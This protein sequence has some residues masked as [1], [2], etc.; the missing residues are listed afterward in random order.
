MES[1]SIAGG[2]GSGLEHRRTRS[3]SR[4]TQERV[5]A[6]WSIP[7]P[8]GR[9]T[10]VAAGSGPHPVDLFRRLVASETTLDSWCRWWHL[11]DSRRSTPGG[12]EPPRPRRPSRPPRFRAHSTAAA[13]RRPTGKCRPRQDMPMARG[14]QS[15]TV[16]LWPLAFSS[17]QDVRRRLLL[18][19]GRTVAREW[20]PP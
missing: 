7:G 12:G 2:P 5:G 11:A 10:P 9:G 3:W 6:W 8:G 20:Q 14:V 15:V 1:P 13:P 18:R 19:Q 17:R 16:H 4:G